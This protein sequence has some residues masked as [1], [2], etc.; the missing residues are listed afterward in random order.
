MTTTRFSVRSADLELVQEFRDLQA[1]TRLPGALLLE[2]A[3]ELLLHHYQDD[4]AE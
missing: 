3:I 1:A 4:D 2:E